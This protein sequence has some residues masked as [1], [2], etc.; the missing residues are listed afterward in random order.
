MFDIRLPKSLLMP[1]S[2]SA[3]LKRYLD[4]FKNAGPFDELESLFDPAL[5]FRGPMFSSDDAKSYIAE[6]ER[7]PAEGVDYV[8]LSS[9]ESGE[10]A[11][12]VIDF[13]KPPVRTPMV[14]WGKFSGDRIKA[15][16]LIFDTGAFR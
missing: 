8:L 11:V 4:I 1:L 2:K 7:S 10:E 13:I 15:L 3:T 12:L 5:R 16:T 6:L 14:V 9:F